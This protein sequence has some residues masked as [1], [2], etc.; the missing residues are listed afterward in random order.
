MHHRLTGLVIVAASAIALYC[1][2]VRAESSAPSPFTAEYRVTYK[3]TVAG[4]AT[5]SMTETAGL[6]E[7]RLVTEAKGLFWFLSKYINST[8]S[9]RFDTNEDGLITPVSYQLERPGQKRGR[10]LLQID[11]SNDTVTVARD[12]GEPVQHTLPEDGAWDRL[13]MLFSVQATVGDDSEG[14]V[15]LNVVNR[16]GPTVKRMELL[17]RATLET[18]AGTFDT[19]HLRYHDSK[20]TADY[21]LATHD[22]GFPV[23]M[24][25]SEDGDDAG[26]LEITKLRR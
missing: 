9:S 4:R 16:H 8:E 3:G 26:S 24:R 21:W 12:I 1:G 18:K 7:T 2:A 6:W 5:I 23:K 14:E 20:R 10:K 13:S 11:F 19:L 15:R 22:G 17:G 25:Y